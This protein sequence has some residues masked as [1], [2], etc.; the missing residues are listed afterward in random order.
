[1]HGS[2]QGGHILQVAL[3]S[4]GLLQIAGVGAAQA[5][6]VGGILDDAFF[7]G[8]SDLPGIDVQGD[9]VLLAQM[10]E[11]GLLVGAGGIFPECPDTAVCVAAD[12]M[13]GQEADH[14]GGDHVQKGFG[15]GLLAHLG[16]GLFRF[17]CQGRFL[18][19]LR[20]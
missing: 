15:V 1:M 17:S 6:L 4:D 9:A 16:S 11:N 3:S 14:R 8:G 10:T 18:L 2:H 12:E 7:F 20:S 19:I 13:V 5:V